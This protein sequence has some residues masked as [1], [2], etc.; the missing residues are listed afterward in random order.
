MA[1]T[2]ARKPKS[3]PRTIVS[4][5]Q[6]DSTIY[7]YILQGE[8]VHEV[9]IID[10]VASCN[11]HAYLYSARGN[12]RCGD[13]DLAQRNEQERGTDLQQHLADEQVYTC[14]CCS[15]RVKTANTYCFGCLA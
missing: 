3:S 8:H 14:V 2:I 13:T 4:R 10:G 7:Y 5:E 15:N 11:C 12:K 9:K 1:T 6:V